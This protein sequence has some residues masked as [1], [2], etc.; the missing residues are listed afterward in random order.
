MKIKK[1]AAAV[2]WKGEQRKSPTVVPETASSPPPATGKGSKKKNKRQL[3]RRQRKFQ[4]LCEKKE[5]F[6]SEQWVQLAREFWVFLVPQANAFAVPATLWLKI[7]PIEGTCKKLN[8]FLFAGD[9]A[10]GYLDAV[11]LF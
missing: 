11:R 3:G 4:Q 1:A 9:L 2:A 8:K 10:L 5:A 6:R 7:E